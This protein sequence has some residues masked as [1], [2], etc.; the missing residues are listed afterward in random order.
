MRVLLIEDESDFIARVQAG[1]AAVEGIDVLNAAQSGL[2]ELK[3]S[4]DTSGP[5]E[6]QLVAKLQTLVARERIDLVMLDTDLSRQHG[7]LS[8]QTEYRQAFQILGIPVC[9]YN[10]GHHPTGLM[11]L[12]LLKRMAKEGD[13]AIFIPR[14]LLAANL[15]LAHSLM[16]HLKGI[17]QGFEMMRELIEKRPEV[18][19]SDLG[20]AGILAKLVGRVGLQADLLG[21]TTQSSNF[22]AFGPA[23]GVPNSVH[24]G[25]QLSYWLYN[26]VLAFPGPIL[27]PVAAAAFVNLSPDSF[28]LPATQALV[29]GCR[30]TGPF[31]VLGPYYW[32][33]DLAALIDGVGG[34]IAHALGLEGQNLERV[35]PEGHAMAY[36]CVLTEKAIRQ[37]EAAVNPDWV[38]LGASLSR[39]LESEFDELG[40]MLRS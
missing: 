20:P 36:Y 34:D 18:L 39:I 15:D 27:N 23:A 21:Y 28:E 8:T 22:F 12:E 29:A 24:Y 25:A 11:N 38:P 33:E 3:A 35:D 1:G 4:F 40:P 7:L 5:I 14:T 9:R 37:D 13:N 30:Y 26:F 31:D 19:E 32:K 16:P 2:L 17:W 10:K 6:E